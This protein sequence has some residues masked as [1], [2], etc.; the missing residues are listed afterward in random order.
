M[1]ELLERGLGHLMSHELGRA[2]ELFQEMLKVYSKDRAAQAGLAICSVLRKDL[3]NTRALVEES[4]S[5]PNPPSLAF[6][7]SGMLSEA[8]GRPEQAEVDFNRALQEEPR[9]VYARY[10]LGV[11]LSRSGQVDDGIIRLSRLTEEYPGFWLARHQLAWGYVR[12]GAFRQA[13]GEAW[14]AVRLKPSAPN[15]RLL[16][17]SVIGAY[18]FVRWIPAILTFLLLSFF[19]NSVP[20]FAILMVVCSGI[21]VLGYWVTERKSLLWLLLLLLVLGAAYYFL[22]AH[23]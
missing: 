23:R 16:V 6:V 21:F 3:P 12:K 4:V 10:A 1:P 15:V 14:R 5:A 20:G 7:A 22:P 2:L 17:L 19:R 8:E 11:F 9:S 18:P 13:L